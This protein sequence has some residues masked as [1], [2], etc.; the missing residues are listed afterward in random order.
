[1]VI[2]FLIKLIIAN[3][4]EKYRSLPYPSDAL[5]TVI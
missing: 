3:P 4:L 1:M 5:I 2:S